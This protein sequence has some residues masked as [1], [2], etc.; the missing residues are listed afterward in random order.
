VDS[1]FLDL[2]HRETKPRESGF[3]F[4][5][6]NG[7]PRRLLTDAIET[8]SG[9][10]DLVK[11]GWGTALVTPDVEGKLAALRHHGVAYCFGGTLF[12]KFVVQ[13]RFDSF[14]TLCRLCGC[15]YVEVSNGTVEIP[16]YEKARYIA[17]CAEE[18]TVLSEVGYK[19]PARAAELT[20]GEL[21]DAVHSD[22]QAGA[23]YVITESRESG[24]S[25]I[26]KPDGTP[27][28]E[29]IGAILD[30]GIDV[31]R[32]IFEAP[33][34]DLQAHFVKLVGPNVNLGNIAVTDVI[35]LETLR[36]GLRSDTLLHFERAV[37][38][39]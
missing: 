34:K 3:T 36:L 8:V 12:E 13:D 32:F 37:S 1:I 22:L 19:D 33:T 39:A 28:E 4:V 16:Q 10:T 26:C 25:G 6:D 2:P 29:L 30:S 15:Q 7:L 24:K 14:L 18:F 23:A 31:N 35:G 5:I 9:Y 27:R 20:P 11:L 21:I 38:C 17:R